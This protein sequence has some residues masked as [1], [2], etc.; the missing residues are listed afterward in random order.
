MA[1]IVPLPANASPRASVRQFM[2]LA[3][4]MPAQ[5]PQPGQATA[6]ICSSSASVICP[7]ATLP[8]ASKTDIRS[9][10]WSPSLLAKLPA[11]IGP[12][13]MNMAGRFNRAAAMSIPGIILSQLGMKTRASKAWASTTTST[14]SAI[15]SRLGRLYFMPG[16][17]IAIPSQTAMVLTSKGTPPPL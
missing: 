14:E 10:R 12:P 17:F 11:S 8:T 6:S 4:N 9:T 7:L 5:L 1:G 15:S 3:V 16:W 13:L 2:V